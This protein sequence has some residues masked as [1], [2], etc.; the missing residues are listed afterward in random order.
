[1]VF[2]AITDYDF[3]SSLTETDFTYESTITAD[4]DG[5]GSAEDA[6]CI[7]TPG[8]T[9]IDG[10][11]CLY[12]ELAGCESAA[13]YADADGITAVESCCACGGGSTAADTP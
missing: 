7:D 1:M 8:W 4:C 9:D 2:Y 5:T 3:A 10:D 11:T 13:A 12:Y 6:A